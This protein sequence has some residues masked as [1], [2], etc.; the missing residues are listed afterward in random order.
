MKYR[1]ITLLCA[2]ALLAACHRGNTIF[3]QTHTLDGNRWNRFTPEEFQ[4]PIHNVEDYYNID[5]TVS[6]DTA[7]YRYGEFPVMVILTSPGGEERQ[8]FHTIMLRENGR[9]RGETRDGYRTVQGRVRSY[10][11]F[12]H[13][14]THTMAVSHTTS[15]YDLEGI[16]SLQVSIEKA[17]LDYNL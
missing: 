17:K 15:Q 16:H 8:F 9:W 6:V 3:D 1:I 5:F 11:T 10:F 14:G 4:I 2:V 13:K 12:N 7:L